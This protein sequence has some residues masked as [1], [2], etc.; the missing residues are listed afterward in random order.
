MFLPL[1]HN[2]KTVN[3]KL[4][5]HGIGVSTRTQAPLSAADYTD[6]T[7][8]IGSILQKVGPNNHLGN[9]KLIYY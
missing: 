8:E 2:L 6:V 1:L 3:F 7:K 5:P 4:H 9:L